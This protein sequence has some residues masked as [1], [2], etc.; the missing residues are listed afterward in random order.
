[1]APGEFAV[2]NRDWRYIRYGSDGEELYNLRSDP[3]EWNNLA[4]DDKYADVIARLRMSAPSEFA[5]PA[6]KLNARKD[7]VVEGESFR[8]E[9]GKGNYKPL[10][11]YRPYTPPT[12]K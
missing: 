5:A 12:A 8:W 10:P 9:K 1:M 11:K 4:S 2:I 3:N 7:L 6:V